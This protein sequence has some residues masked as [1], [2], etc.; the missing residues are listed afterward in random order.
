V[1]KLFLNKRIESFDKLVGMMK[2]KIGS[3]PKNQKEKVEIIK[4]LNMQKKEL[5]IQKRIINDNIRRINAKARADRAA[6]TGVRG[7]GLIGTAARIDRRTITNRKEEALRPLESQKT[8]IERLLANLDSEILRI[9]RIVSSDDS[10]SHANEEI[11][12]KCKYCG[13]ELGQVNTCPG[14]GAVN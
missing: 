4:K 5:G 8:E 10:A 9:S 6:W 3:I 2:N 7:N 13:R 11:N 14:C 1:F 12:Q